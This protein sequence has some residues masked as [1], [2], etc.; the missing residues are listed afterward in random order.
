MEKGDERGDKKSNENSNSSKGKGKDKIPS[1][2]PSKWAKYHQGWFWLV[3]FF[4]KFFLLQEYSSS[5]NIVNPD[6]DVSIISRVWMR[7]MMKQMIW[8]LLNPW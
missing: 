8:T 7:V 6:R 3:L 2:E 4:F 1:V 5:L